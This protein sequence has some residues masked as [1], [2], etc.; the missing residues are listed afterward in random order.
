MTDK[1]S[2]L[3]VD[4]HPLMRKGLHQLIDMEEGLE[5]IGEAASGDEAVRMAVANEPDVVLLDL[6]MP[7]MSGVDTLKALRTAEVFSR[8]IVFT[9]SDDQDDVIT[10]LKA[11]ADGYLLKDTDPDDVMAAIHQVVAGQL[12]ISDRLS[13]VLASAISKR[14]EA[15]P[16]IDTLTER[17]KQILKAIAAGYSN[18]IIGRKLDIAEGT[19]KVHVKKVLK[20]LGFRSR[21]EAAIWAVEQGMR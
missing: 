4:D 14:R 19:V 18:K 12:T 1:H 9:V 5:C 2:V 3:I 16:N 20:K 6:N 8:I 10:A 15:G 17:E 11:G 21:V 13:Q 7:G